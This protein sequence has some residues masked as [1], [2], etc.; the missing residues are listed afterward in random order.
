MITHRI[1]DGKGSTKTVRLSP[2][3]A[4]LAFCY[5]CMGWNQAE[6]ERCTSPEC[7][8]Y[9]FR[10]RKATKGVQPR[11]ELQQKHDKLMAKKLKNRRKG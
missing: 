4:I 8:L 10:N 9:P 1:K 7:P 6:V 3:T 2:R 5:E 11:S